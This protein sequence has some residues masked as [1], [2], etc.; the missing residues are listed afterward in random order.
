MVKICWLWIGRF[1]I[2]CFGIAIGAASPRTYSG[3]VGNQAASDEPFSR[4]SV[5]A[6]HTSLDSLIDEKA[7]QLVLGRLTFLFAASAEC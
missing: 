3:E 2:L 6:F 5:L 1:C 7:K 4:V